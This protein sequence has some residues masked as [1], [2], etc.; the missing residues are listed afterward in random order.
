M[1]VQSEII[2]KV[3]RAGVG[4]R[5]AGAS[6]ATRHRPCGDQPPPASADR[7]MPGR[8][9]HVLRHVPLFGAHP[10]GPFGRSRRYGRQP[11]DVAARLPCAG[12]QQAKA[13][14]ENPPSSFPDSARQFGQTFA[15]LQ[16]KRHFA[17]YDSDRLVGKY[18][19][20]A[21]INDARTAIDRFLATPAIVRCDFA[22]HMLMKV[23]PD[24]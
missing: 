16:S 18:E 14:C 7:S 11:A 13:R 8:Q 6:S 5:G 17:D 24:A 12:S 21:D 3:E 1:S 22:L 2:D 4:H 23:R 20:T 9:H 15:E 19:V 10:R